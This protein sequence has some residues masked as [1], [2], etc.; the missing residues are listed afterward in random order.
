[1]HDNMQRVLQHVGCVVVDSADNGHYVCVHNRH[2]SFQIAQ[3]VV[4]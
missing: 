2:W 3:A 4:P 1:M